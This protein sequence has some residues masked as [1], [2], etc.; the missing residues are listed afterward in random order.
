MM[1]NILPFKNLKK[2]G[3]NLEDM[4]KNN[5]PYVI[6][7]FIDKMNLFIM[8]F[9]KMYSLELRDQEGRNIGGLF[10]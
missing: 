5:I 7:I 8:N 9:K 6:N 1:K 2:I 3:F 4:N 10:S